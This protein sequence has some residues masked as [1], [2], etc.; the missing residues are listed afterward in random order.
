MENK[1]GSAAGGAWPGA[2]GVR[3]KLT[4][5]G[6]RNGERVGQPLGDARFAQIMLAVDDCVSFLI[7]KMLVSV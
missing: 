1:P 7:N 3:G 6:E 4:R 5:A 2:G